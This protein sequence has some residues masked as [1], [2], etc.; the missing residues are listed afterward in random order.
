[1]IRKFEDLSLSGSVT[2]KGGYCRLQAPHMLS[3][4]LAGFDSAKDGIFRPVRNENLNYARRLLP[5]AFLLGFYRR[6]GGWINAFNAVYS[7]CSWVCGALFFSPRSFHPFQE[8]IDQY[9]RINRKTGRFLWLM[10]SSSS[11]FLKCQ[12]ISR[13]YVL[14]EIFQVSY[15]GAF[16]SVNGRF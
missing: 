8:F 10:G 9:H 12:T 4:L 1:M 16:R 13:I 5:R 11:D 15:M 3:D 2:Q 7:S 14:H 6:S